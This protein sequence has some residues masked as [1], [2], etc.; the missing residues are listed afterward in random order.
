MFRI[1]RKD[2]LC[3][4]FSPREGDHIDVLGLGRCLVVGREPRLFHVRPLDASPTDDIV[5]VRYH[6]NV[7]WTTEDG[8]PVD[9]TIQDPRSHDTTVT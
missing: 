9:T 2:P 5:K 4:C 7:Q 3:L 6:I 8:Q 1:K